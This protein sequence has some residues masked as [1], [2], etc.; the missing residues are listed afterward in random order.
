MAVNR[1]KDTKKGNKYEGESL[2]PECDFHG[3]KTSFISPCG[4]A[5]KEGRSKRV[6]DGG[7]PASVAYQEKPTRIGT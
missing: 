2:Y 6:M 5:K 4:S 1:E 3:A 7:S